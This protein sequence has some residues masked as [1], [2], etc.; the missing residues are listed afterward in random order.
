[1]LTE[2][3]TEKL[4]VK[5]ERLL[6]NFEQLIE[7]DLSLPDYCGDIVK[8]LNCCTQTNIFSAAITGDKA[9]IDG[10]VVI[11]MLYINS[12]SKTEIYETSVPFNRSIDAKDI[13][14]NDVIDI[15]C[16]SEQVSCRAV[17]QRRADIRGSIT[18]RVSIT[19]YD[20]ISIISEIP[21]GYCHALSNTADGSILKVGCRKYFT[22]TENSGNEERFRNAKVLRACASPVITEIRTIKNK[23]MIR[24]NLNT[25]VTLIDSS[26]NFITATVHITLNQITDIEGIDED[27]VCNVLL[28]VSALDV[29]ISPETAS[30]PPHIEVS[31]TLAATIEVTEKTCITAFTEA[32]APHCDIV[33]EKASIKYIEDIHRIKESHA[34]S[35]KFDFASSNATEVCDVELRRIRFSACNENNTPVMRGNLHFGITLKTADGEKL[36]F[37]RI[38]DFEHRISA[39]CET[40]DFEFNPVVTP[41]AA[42]YS[43]SGDGTVTVHSEFRID[44]HLYCL[45]EFSALSSIEKG[46][47]KPCDKDKSVFTVYFASKGEKLWNIAKTHNTSTERIR[48]LNPDV[49]DETQSE[50]LLVFEQE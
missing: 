19:G 23:M 32:Y 49:Q 36:W 17:N 40:G 28:N 46:E 31:A 50:C 43:I 2:F 4:M 7:N 22:V 24:G 8:I 41:L 5:K 30:A 3:K 6:R 34:L 13:S 26:G 18:L 21:D 39:G 38:S 42:E 33:C 35:V 48:N 12:S 10:A 20:E 14:E 37:E 27:S 9:V 11:R 45:R 25:D 1:M 15:T 16:I 29:R 44:G 47:K